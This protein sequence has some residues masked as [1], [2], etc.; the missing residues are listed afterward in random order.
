[1]EEF[2]NKPILDQLYEAISEEFEQ[3]IYENDSKMREVEGNVQDKGDRLNTFF[4]EKFSNPEDLDKALYLFREYEMIYEKEIELWCKFYFKLGF[5]DRVKLRNELFIKNGNEEEHD[6]F[7]N[8]DSDDFSDWIEKQKNKHTFGTKEY[9]E[10]QKRYNEISEKYP[11]AIEVFEDLTP[12]ELTKDEMKALVELRDIDIAMGH[13][14][15]YLC[16]KLGMKEVIN[17]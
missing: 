5:S 12:I 3:T 9:K 14:E 17:F 2:F 13:M 16:F 8:Y 10:L 15:K 1:M 4:R 11:N 7:F 6:T